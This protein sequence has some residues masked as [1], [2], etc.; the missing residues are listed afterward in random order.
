ML[1]GTW[2]SQF[3][4][5]SFPPFFEEHYGIFE[6]LAATVNDD[7]RPFDIDAH[8]GDDPCAGTRF[9]FDEND[10]WKL[11]DVPTSRRDP[12]E[13]K[14]DLIAALKTQRFMRTLDDYARLHPEWKPSQIRQFKRV[15]A[16][17]PIDPQNVVFYDREAFITI[18]NVGSLTLVC[19]QN[20]WSLKQCL[21]S[22]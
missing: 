4:A 15:I 2:Q 10:Q 5:S 13:L 17:D 18:P 6:E 22:H 19:S 11:E 1:G 12:E 3:T 9:I 14:G 16:Y 8:L 21:L 20:S 7:I